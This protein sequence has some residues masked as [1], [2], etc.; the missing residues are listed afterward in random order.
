[1]GPGRRSHDMNQ[2]RKSGSGT[3]RNAWAT[4]E[5]K[6]V[7]YDG[8]GDAYASFFSNRRRRDE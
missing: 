4:R 1:V 3:N 2:M 7:D 5:E 8:N 6:K